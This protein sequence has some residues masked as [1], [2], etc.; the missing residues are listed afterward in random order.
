MKLIH[1]VSFSVD[2]NRK[3]VLQVFEIN[4]EKYLLDELPGKEKKMVCFEV[5]EDHPYWPD[6]EYLFKKWDAFDLTSTEFTAS[7]LNHASYLK[8]GCN[9][10]HGYPMPDDDFGYC[11][12]T[13]EHFCDKC[14]IGK[15]KAP[16]RMRSKP[17]WG[18]R[19][20]FR[21]HWVY[22]EYFVLPEVW[23][24]VF[25]PVGIGSLPVLHHRTGKELETVV[26]LNIEKVAT[27]PLNTEG[28]SCEICT[29]CGT[30]R[31]KPISRGFQPALTSAQDEPI[32]KTLEYFGSG[33]SSSKTVIVLAK[34]YQV[35]EK[36]KLKGVVFYP[37]AKQ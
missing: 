10:H 19:H 3:K 37:L 32:F 1:R 16:F 35:I 18:K 7:E 30:K 5:A 11:S 4:A 6:L 27:A 29:V 33:A 14:G 20:I 12:V 31:Y 26:Q 21:L 2:D 22:D 36:E 34:L 24:E 8:M 13:Y 28:L 9:W 23:E 15:Q 25:K 17:Q